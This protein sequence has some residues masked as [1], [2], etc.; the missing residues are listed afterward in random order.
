[1]TKDP[2][3]FSSIVGRNRNLFSTI[4]YFLKLHERGEEGGR[5]EEGGG[6]M[7]TTFMSSKKLPK[8]R[9]PSKAQNSEYKP[10]SRT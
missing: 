10:K 4:I 9:S 3:F 2:I 7:Q 5:Q 6:I 1:M 8:Y